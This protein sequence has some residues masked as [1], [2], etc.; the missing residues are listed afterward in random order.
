MKAVRFYAYGEPSTLVYEEDVPRP[1]PD[2]G[3]VLIS[4]RA[5]GVNP[6]NWKIR[7]GYMRQM[8]DFSLPLILGMD[9]SGV[10]VEVGANSKFEPGQ[11]VYG[12]AELGVSGAYAEFALAAEAAI[13]LKPKT[14]SHVEAAS[15]P[16]VASTAWQ[17]LLDVGRLSEGEKVLIHA[18]AGGV[19]MFAVQLA[20]W[21][22]AY[23]IGTASG[24]NLDFVRQLGADEVIDYQTTAFEEVVK[25][26]DMVLDTL[27]G[28]SQEK[29][30]GV[31][32]PEGILVSTI[33]PPSQE[34]AEIHGVRAAMIMVQ[35]TNSLLTEIANLIDKGEL[36]T[37]VD[38]VIPLSNAR[39][40]HE[41]CQQGHTRGKLVLQVSG[42]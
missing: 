39:E 13:S 31:L 28:E 5:A 7:A 9:V 12:V 30:W 3:Q 41:I 8:M 32:K 1:Q 15:I 18:A 37:S 19:G 2:S 22:G 6:L 26:V 40:A 4:V 21:Q 33:S 24:R 16:V 35:P 42:A 34:T 36:K 14:L 23:V 27:G 11:E 29:S 20:K 17:A 38:R 25:D 10:V